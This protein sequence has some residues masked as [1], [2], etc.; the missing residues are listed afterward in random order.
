MSIDR[1]RWMVFPSPPCVVSGIRH[2]P[3]L[4]QQTDEQIPP[5]FCLTYQYFSNE[6]TNDYTHTH[7][8]PPARIRYEEMAKTR[9][10]SLS[11]LATDQE[12]HEQVN[13]CARMCSDVRC[14]VCG[15]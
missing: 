5:G 9:G 6:R 11:M 12:R 2:L 10:A 13:K 15:C 8:R 4:H 14:L 7:T 3:I 1:P